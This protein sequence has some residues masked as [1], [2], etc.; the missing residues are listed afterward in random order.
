MH[1]QFSSE[2]IDN[3][4]RHAGLQSFVQEKGID[5]SCGE[6]GSNLSGGERQRISIAR[7]LLKGTPV[8]LMDEA[9]ASLDNL[10][11]L[12][13]ESAI[14]QL[15]GLTKIIVTHRLNEDLLKKLDTIFVLKNGLLV[16]SGSFDDL[17]KQKSYFS[18]LYSVE[19][20][21]ELYESENTTSK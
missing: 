19:S 13:V 11:A 8:I 15:E 1:K 5:Y 14:L 4:I 10:T 6:C 3:A 16:E 2:S 18:S 9:T 17:L 21:N 20:A 7:T 12:E